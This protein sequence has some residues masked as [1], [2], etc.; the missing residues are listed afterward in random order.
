[1]SLKD[2]H[3]LAINLCHC[4]QLVFPWVCVDKRVLSQKLSIANKVLS[5][6]AC[7]YH[8]SSNCILWIFNLCCNILIA[9]LLTPHNNTRFHLRRQNF[10]MQ[11]SYY[12]W[13][14]FWSIKKMVVSDI[15]F[16]RRYHYLWRNSSYLSDF[17]LWW[18]RRSLFLLFL[19]LTWIVY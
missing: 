4:L 16:Q 5:T 10:R 18:M 2:W 7:S 14:C 1:M 12:L 17:L 3:S 9:N 13:D 6:L 8:F 19:N 15:C 11:G